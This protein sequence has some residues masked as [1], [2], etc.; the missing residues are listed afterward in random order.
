MSIEAYAYVRR[1]TFGKNPGRKLVL[2]NLADTVDD[3]T[4]SWAIKPAVLAVDSE[5]ETR[6]AQNHLKALSEDGYLSVLERFND[7]GKQTVS[8]LRLHGPWDL[9]GGTGQP[10]SETERPKKDRRL[11]THTAQELSQE[12]RI[13][14]RRRLQ[15]LVDREGFF[16]DGRPRARWRLGSRAHSIVCWYG[17]GNTVLHDG[18]AATVVAITDRDGKKKASLRVRLDYGDGP[19]ET[20]VPVENL[21][22]PSQEN[23]SSSGV[24]SSTPTPNLG[25]QPSAPH[26]VQPSALHGVQPSAPLPHQYSPAPRHQAAQPSMNG[27]RVTGSRH[28]EDEKPSAQKNGE[29]AIEIVMRRTGA[30]GDEAQELVD[31]LV[32][33]ALRRGRPIESLGSYVNGFRLEDLTHR[34]G[35]IRRQRAPQPHAEASGGGRA[36]V[37]SLHAP[38][39]V[40]CA[41]CPSDLVVGGTAAQAVVDLYLSLGAEAA[42]L[43]PDL[44]RHPKIAA[45]ATTG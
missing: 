19:A 21:T 30:T 34:L 26:G 15:E 27:S 20:W 40:P 35:E 42:T 18:Q 36:S 45:L 13:E 32:A 10:F 22:E 43:R 24:H 38:N 28:E 9:W 3:D 1:L 7:Q 41:A 44:A 37:C 17:L 12:T 6:Q 5:M 31:A 25:V 8:R 2:G 39:P 4:K 11:D 29:T 23:P 33:S 14:L 16:A